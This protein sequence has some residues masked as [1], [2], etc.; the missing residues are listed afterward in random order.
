MLQLKQKPCHSFSTIFFLF[1]CFAQLH[2]KASRIVLMCPFICALWKWAVLL[3]VRGSKLHVWKRGRL[4]NNGAAN[5]LV[6]CVWIIKV[7]L[8]II[9]SWLSWREPEEWDRSRECG[10]IVSA[11]GVHGLCLFYVVYCDLDPPYTLAHMNP[12]QDRTGIHIHS[13]CIFS[14]ERR[15]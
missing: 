3:F 9:K 7:V 13:N 5:G 8:L 4:W 1:C 2:G 12:A 6:C 15:P 14:W 11:A 10:I